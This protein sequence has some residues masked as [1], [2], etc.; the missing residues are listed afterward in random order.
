M[1][2]SGGE[3]E[4]SLE[5]LLGWE[6]WT[7]DGGSRERACKSCLEKDFLATAAAAAAGVCPS[8]LLLPRLVHRLDKRVSGVML[9]ARHPDAAAWAAACFRDKVSQARAR[10]QEKNEGGRR[11]KRGCQMCEPLTLHSSRSDET[12][13]PSPRPLRK[14]NTI[15][16]AHSPSPAGP[17]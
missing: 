13:P 15:P 16:P 12:P 11:R 3:S 7:T 9:V 14:Q 8:L 17:P 10:G 2:A 5:G 6:A 1:R 4:E